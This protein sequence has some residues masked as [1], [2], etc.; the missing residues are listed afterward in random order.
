MGKAGDFTSTFSV[1]HLVIHGGGDAGEEVQ[2]TLA[3]E[4]S[5]PRAV[6]STLKGVPS[7]PK[8]V[9]STTG[10]VPSGSTV[11]PTT[12]GRVP[13]TPVAEL[14]GLTTHPTSMWTLVKIMQE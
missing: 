3:I 13:N 5:T 4:L 14:R 11:V 9:P 8:G 12:P 2:T 10:V 1:E 6:P 7:T